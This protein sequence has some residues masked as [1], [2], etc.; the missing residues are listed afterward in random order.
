LGVYSGQ[1][2]QLAAVI[3]NLELDQFYKT[4]VIY[5]CMHLKWLANELTAQL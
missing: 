1:A 4:Y 2:T 5:K 3:S